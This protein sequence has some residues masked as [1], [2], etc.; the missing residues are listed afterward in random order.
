M[1]ATFADT[2][3]LRKT[4]TWIWD[5]RIRTVTTRRA[6]LPVTISDG[7]QLSFTAAMRRY[8]GSLFSDPCTTPSLGDQ[9]LSGASEINSVG[10]RT[11]R[12]T[13]FRRI[14]SWHD[15]GIWADGTIAAAGPRMRH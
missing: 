10:L 15:D 14:T 1:S 12:A 2:T 7:L 6:L 3:T 5:S 11:R 13:S 9:N 4:R 8:D